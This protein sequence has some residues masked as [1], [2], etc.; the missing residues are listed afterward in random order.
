MEGLGRLVRPKRSER[1]EGL[2]RME[3]PE[4]LEKQERLERSQKLK[5]VELSRF[6]CSKVLYIKECPTDSSVHHS[7]ITQIRYLLYKKD[8]NCKKSYQ[9]LQT[10]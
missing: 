8:G 3:R 4:R 10:Y 9:I 6:Y 2:E 7:T 5:I 1:M